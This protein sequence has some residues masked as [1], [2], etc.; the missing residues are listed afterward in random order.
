MRVE[1]KSEAEAPDLLE[2]TARV[3]ASFVSNHRV[4]V[5]DLPALI[6]STYQ[7]LAS[8]DPRANRESGA[9]D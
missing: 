2:L 7:A 4:R 6:N 8:L 3:V 1:K 5:P 9:N